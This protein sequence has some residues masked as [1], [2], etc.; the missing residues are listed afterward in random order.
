MAEVCIL[1]WHIA[2]FRSDRFL[3]LWEQA[4]ARMPAYGAK[5]WSLIRSVDD[6]LA[7]Q[8]ASIWESRADFE[9]WW[10]SEEV[11]Q[12][13]AAVIGMHDIPIL[14]SWHTLLAAE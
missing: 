2:P 8:H 13:R 11:E 5:S 4:A 10:F 7:V 9:R 14:P 6:P 12:A 1:D 3:D